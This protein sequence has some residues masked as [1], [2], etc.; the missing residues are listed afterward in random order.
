MGIM[1]YPQVKY[2]EGN[3]V[4]NIVHVYVQWPVGGE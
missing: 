3:I 2:N 1:K 4:N